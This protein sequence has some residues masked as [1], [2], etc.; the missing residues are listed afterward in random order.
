MGLAAWYM[1]VHGIKLPKEAI[2][3]ISMPLADTYYAQSRGVDWLIG[4]GLSI[5]S[6]W[7]GSVFPA[8]RAS[9]VPVTAAL[10]KGV[11]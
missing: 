3:A 7:A 5:F 9:R 10:A 8:R 1:N 11:R 2:E 6:A 4:A